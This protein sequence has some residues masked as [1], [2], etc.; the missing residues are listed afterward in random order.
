MTTVTLFISFI[1]VLSSIF[2][3]ISTLEALEEVFV[4]VF[5]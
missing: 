1:Y 5:N 4:L 3:L 2:R